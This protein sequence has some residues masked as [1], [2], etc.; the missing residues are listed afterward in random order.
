MTTIRELFSTR[1]PID[2]PI[3][4]VIDYQA[5]DG[6]RLRA[7]VEEYEVTANIERSLQRFVEAYGQGVR[8][9]QVTEIGIWVSGFY[10]SGKSSFTKY[11]GF[12][13]DADK[14]V[15]DRSF[16]DLLCER[17][18]ATGLRAELRTLTQQQPTS[19][20]LLDLGAEMLASN[21]AE[22]VANVLYWKT[23][24][25]A[26]YSMEKKLAELELKLEQKGLLEKFRELY[27]AKFADEWE[28]VHD[29]P[30]SGVA[31]AAQF[32]T[33]L[34]PEDFPT[35][36]SFR[37][38]RFDLT[39]SV[40][41]LVRT[42]VEIVRRRSGR[43][44][45]LFL[46]DEA[47]QYVAQR[48]ELLL[49]LDGLARTLK[50][51]GQGR[52]WIACT[53]QQT[54]SEVIQSQALNALQLGA[55]KDRFPI[56]IDLEARDIREIT[57]KRL[58]T[59]SPEGEKRL[60]EEF[61]RTGQALVNHTRLSGTKLFSGDPSA[62]EFRQFYP[63]LP[64]HFDLLLELIRNLARTTS[65]IGLRSAI[66][67][68]QDLLVDASNLRPSGATKIADRPLGAL[69]CADDF[70]DT[71]RRDIAR[72]LPHVTQA[73]DERVSRVF[74]DDSWVLRVAK[75]IGALQP[76]DSFPRTAENL[77]ALLYPS[78]GHPEILTQVRSALQRLEGEKECG[79]INDPVSGGYQ[80][81]SDSVRDFRRK[82]NEYIPREAEINQERSALVKQIFESVPFAMIQN[83][84]T[85]KAGIRYG[86]TSIVEPD[87]EVQ[88]RLEPL[89]RTTLSTRRSDLLTETAALPE[90]KN[91]IAWLFVP[92]D[93]LE[94]LLREICRSLRVTQTTATEVDR[95]LT[96][97]LRAEKGALDR[98]REQAKR[99]LR[100]ALSEGMFVF[101][102]AGT[103][104]NERSS[105]VGVAANAQV[106]V[107]AEELY[108]HLRLV[109]I[110]PATDLAQRFLSVE[111][112]DRMTREA[113]PLSLVDT[114][115]RG[116]VNTGHDALAETLREFRS[117]VEA[118]GTGRIQGNAILDVFAAPPYGW[119][120][121]AT[122]YLFAGL[123]VSGEIKL[124]TPDG[125]LTT[126][127][128]KAIDALSSTVKFNRIGVSTRESRPSPEMLENAAT[129]LE[130]ILAEEVFPLEDKIAAAVR[131]K[132]PGLIERFSA[133]P[134]RLRV[135]GL[136]GEERAAVL[137]DTLAGLLVQEAAGAPAILGA[138]D[139][140]IPSEVKW[141]QKVVDALSPETERMIV[142]ARSLLFGV[143]KIMEH[144]PDE[145]AGLLAADEAAFIEDS[146]GSEQIHEK[147][148]D[149]EKGI[150]G[151]CA[152][153]ARLHER[154][155]LAFDE[156]RVQTL[157]ALQ[158]M[159]EWLRLSPEIQG[160]VTARLM[161]LQVSPEAR[162][163]KEIEDVELLLTR[164]GQLATRQIQLER[165]IREA[166]A[167]VPQPP[168]TDPV[169]SVGATPDEE[170]ID[171]MTLTPTDPLRTEEDL[172]TW[173][174]GVKTRLVQ[175]LRHGK[176]IRFRR[177]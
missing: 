24:R 62:D 121:D 175:A 114:H 134:D 102:G 68:I 44:N 89:D 115:G 155:A 106:K 145:T 35:P 120:K 20:I 109:P 31:R 98:H 52:I 123:L 160:E 91:R 131:A 71:L 13:L 69:A 150:R 54:L 19:V 38:L 1:R 51:V 9:G 49:N 7:E 140:T 100:A 96:Q 77:A 172:N 99:L 93:E 10:G 116:R 79:V 72:T 73:V 61:G 174:E 25:W 40:Q 63:F 81:L 28:K 161:E 130:A 129:N 101:R 39:R 111:R 3:E 127:G 2:R 4:K 157:G 151:L 41:D 88:F 48:S 152:G 122:R 42:M 37:S 156:R 26:G 137:R 167:P 165:Q 74:A 162:E 159:P 8:T 169:P 94:D 107:A 53:G 154:L 92:P 66:R 177:G 80:Y 128:P 15:D 124:H 56:A 18:P 139:C 90:W 30:L 23:L 17:L 22:P 164:L 173:I 136:P 149:L 112:L 147:L 21:A 95:D 153:T 126:P 171:P 60:R 104:V 64:Q 118:S 141:A 85:V 32:V 110:R 6:D 83:V 143:R 67:V 87:A 50:E 45:I 105:D 12:A 27:R 29:D 148:L 11:L 70:Y 158:S 36:E 46:I 119:S 84:K 103:P 170:V 176:S 75:A 117:R 5:A 97:Y 132:M 163:G 58:L 125:E 47:G 138:K 166:A 108:P 16:C 146:L 142:R 168:S 43:Q 14:M 82:R 65:G 86:T 33:E 59:K 135:L 133:L 144:H 57:Y 76:I 78:L 113:D 34:L 55:L